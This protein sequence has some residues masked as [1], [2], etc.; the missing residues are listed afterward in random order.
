MTAYFFYNHLIFVCF[1]VLYERLPI[2]MRRG[3]QRH[4]MPRQARNDEIS[5]TSRNVNSA[6]VTRARREY[7]AWEKLSERSAGLNQAKT[8]R[9]DDARVRTMHPVHFAAA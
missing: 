8:A 3:I 1:T 5:L 2:P 4:W 6:Q 9:K 7:R